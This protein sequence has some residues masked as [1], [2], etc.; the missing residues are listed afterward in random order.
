MMLF[1][2][3]M[4]VCL[5]TLSLPL[6][7]LSTGKARIRVQVDKSDRAYLFKVKVEDVSLDLSQVRAV[8]PRSLIICCCLFLIVVQ[9]CEI[10]LCLP[11]QFV[12]LLSGRCA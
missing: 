11:F 3:T 9:L 7:V 8:S 2:E 4:H 6:Q 1:F 12:H 5:C 10:K